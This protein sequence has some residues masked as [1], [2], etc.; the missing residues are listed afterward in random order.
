M[1]APCFFC[2]K[3]TYTP[4]HVTE[5]HDGVVNAYHMCK[6]CGDDYF[7]EFIPEPKP[8]KEKLDL[9]HIK[10]PEELLDF[11][12]GVHPKKT[13]DK[14]PCECGLTIED[15]EKKG[16]FGCPKCYTHFD[17]KMEE[18]VFPYHKARE[19]VGK[20]PKRLMQERM[21]ND[22]VEKLKL[23]KLKY[24]KALELEEYEKLRDLKDQID[25]VIREIP[26]ISEDQ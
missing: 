8:M 1:I 4:Y 9:T 6:S 15:F 2:N 21:E 12:S 17:E 14:K 11:L 18:L 16:K 3:T 19:H 26:S 24:A 22:P 10:T 7:K 5:I 13:S 20:Q 23:L 25:E